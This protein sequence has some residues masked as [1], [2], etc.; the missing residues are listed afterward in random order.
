[1]HED[2]IHLTTSDDLRRHTGPGLAMV[3]FYAPWC[4][5][6]K[7]FAP[8]FEQLANDYE[9]DVSFLAVNVDDAPQLA[10]SHDAQKIPTVVLFENGS[11]ID[12]WVNEQDEQPYRKAL[13]EAVATQD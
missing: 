8:T 10:Q 3:K 12:R 5:H 13:N 11:E 6:C 9:G 7:Q 1:M 4:G 2:L